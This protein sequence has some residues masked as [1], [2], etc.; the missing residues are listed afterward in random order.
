MIEQTEYLRP[1]QFVQHLILI[2]GLTP[3]WIKSITPAET[4]PGQN[5]NLKDFQL[6][7]SA[8]P[9]PPHNQPSSQ[10]QKE[11]DHTQ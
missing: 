9:K 8:S 2:A 7:N 1:S 10:N 3:T 11:F 5:W 6:K 4:L